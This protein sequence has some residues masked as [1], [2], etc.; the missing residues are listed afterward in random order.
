[1]LCLHV[2]HAHLATMHYNHVRFE[3]LRENIFYSNIYLACFQNQ[4]ISRKS[5]PLERGGE[6]GAITNGAPFL[7]LRMNKYKWHINT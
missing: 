5:S 4:D 7:S 6:G 2:F 3:Q 1:M